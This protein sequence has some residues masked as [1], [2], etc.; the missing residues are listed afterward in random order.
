MKCA[1]LSFAAYGFL[2]ALIVVAVLLYN[3]SRGDVVFLIKVALVCG[4]LL[5]WAGSSAYALHKN[6]GFVR[7]FFLVGFL[8]TLVLMGLIQ[9][10]T[11][12]LEEEIH[13]VLNA[14][15]IVSGVFLIWLW[16]ALFRAVW[17]RRSQAPRVE[18]GRQFPSRASRED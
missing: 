16:I 18:K 15:R 5:V 2:I 11:F 8:T 9:Y 10:G 4:G 17:I 12:Q 13:P 1:A 7:S 6:R 14:L 3:P